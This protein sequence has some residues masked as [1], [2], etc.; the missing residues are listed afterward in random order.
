MQYERGV[1]YMSY[2]IG[3]IS[4]QFF[5]QLDEQATLARYQ[6]CYWYSPYVCRCIAMVTLHQCARE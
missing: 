1:A 2:D 4:Y 3:G 5:L 6:T